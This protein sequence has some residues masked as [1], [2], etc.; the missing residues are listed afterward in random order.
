MSMA[1][2]GQ[3]RKWIPAALSGRRQGIL[4][5]GFDES[6]APLAALLRNRLVGGVESSARELPPNVPF[7]GTM[8]SLNVVCETHHPGTLVVSGKPAVGLSSAELLRLHY[9]GIEM[10]SAPLLYERVL[11]RVA[12]QYMQPSELLFFLNPG[13]S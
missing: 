1:L 9:S 8:D 6:M 5:A 7:L 13:T 11:Q 4:L 12:W 3:L 2:A 10:E